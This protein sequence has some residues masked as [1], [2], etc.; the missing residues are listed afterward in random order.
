MVF[1][2][3]SVQTGCEVSCKNVLFFILCN[4]KT[5]RSWDLK[6]G[7]FHAY[8]EVYEHPAIVLAKSEMVEWE[9]FRHLVME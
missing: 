2:D 7:T 3:D 6:F 5:I 9:P 1:R 8:W 4:A